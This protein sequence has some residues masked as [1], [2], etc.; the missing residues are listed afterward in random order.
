MSGTALGLWLLA[1]AEL[2]SKRDVPYLDGS[3]E[4]S[5]LGVMERK[6]PS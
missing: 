2:A 3:I 4:K 5:A 1:Y 6:R